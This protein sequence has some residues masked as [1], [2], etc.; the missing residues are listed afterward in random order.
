MIDKHFIIYRTTNLLNKRFYIGKHA[1]ENL[2]DGYLGSGRR[3]LHEIKKYGRENFVR[4]IIETLP[5]ETSLRKR[6]QEIVNAEL[7]RDP[8]CLNL[9]NGGQGGW[10]HIGSDA[11]KKRVVSFVS[12]TTGRT[13]TVEHREAI[14][15]SKIGN[16]PVNEIVSMEL[17]GL[18]MV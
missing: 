6:E 12:T 16:L 4:E 17:V 14:R 8:L 3:I 2:D 5:D 18:P 13:Y 1:T 7:L 9:K 10:D 11:I 15:R